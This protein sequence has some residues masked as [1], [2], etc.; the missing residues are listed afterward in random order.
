[1]LFK[2]IK[3]DIVKDIVSRWSWG[4]L[5]TGLPFFS[6]KSISWIIRLDKKSYKVCIKPKKYIFCIIKQFI[7]KRDNR[8]TEKIMHKPL[9][10]KLGLKKKERFMVTGIL[11]RFMM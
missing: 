1:M 3:T 4:S 2:E 7:L 11:S 8:Q 9:N 5:L 10:L 6:R